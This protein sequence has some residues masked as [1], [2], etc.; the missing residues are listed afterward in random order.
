MLQ[1]LIFFSELYGEW[2][3]FEFL[4]H[5]PREEHKSWTKAK[6]KQLQ[7]NPGVVR[8]VAD[9]VADYE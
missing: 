2:N 8:L 7:E 4:Q 3:I 9:L 1:S 6:Q 5:K